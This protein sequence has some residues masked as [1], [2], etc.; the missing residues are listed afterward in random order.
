MQSSRRQASLG[1]P[2]RDK[3]QRLDNKPKL[4]EAG[5]EVSMERGFLWQ[6]HPGLL[7]IEALV[8]HAV[9]HGWA[10]ATSARERW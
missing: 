4:G 6:G 2:C 7:F 8:G 3:E 1:L 5:S 9:I 10:D